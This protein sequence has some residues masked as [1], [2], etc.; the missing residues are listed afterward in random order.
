MKPI[1]T[2]NTNIT[3]KLPGGTEENDLPAYRIKDTEGDE[4][5]CSVWEPTPEERERIA[6]GENLRLIMWAQRP[7]PVSIDVTDE[8]V[9]PA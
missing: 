2:I 5:L 4:V 6:N 9:S 1:N 7:L 3:F 8:I